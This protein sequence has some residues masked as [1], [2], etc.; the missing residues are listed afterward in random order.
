MELARVDSTIHN[1]N[2]AH[3]RLQLV[4]SLLVGNQVA[5]LVSFLKT[6]KDFE[7]DSIFD[8][9]HKHIKKLYYYLLGKYLILGF[10]ELSAKENV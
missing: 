8:V 10:F 2:R 3:L 6:V 1:N 9:A 4:S 7:Y 5:L